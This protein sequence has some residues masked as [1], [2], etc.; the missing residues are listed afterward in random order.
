M[1]DETHHRV[2]LLDSKGGFSAA[3]RLS[4]LVVSFRKTNRVTRSFPLQSV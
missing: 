4:R 1:S 3:D 2:D